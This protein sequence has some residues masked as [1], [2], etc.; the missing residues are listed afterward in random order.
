MT[1]QHL[2]GAQ[3]LNSKT[4]ST[5]CLG[6]LPSP[7]ASWA[8]HEY[9]YAGLSQSWRRR[10]PLLKVKH[11]G[12]PAGPQM[13]VAFGVVSSGALLE[14]ENHSG[15]GGDFFTSTDITLEFQWFFLN[16]IKVTVQ[17]REELT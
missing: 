4:S 14:A 12:N 15:G 5:A 8:H 2:Q 13:Y 6:L 10:L 17:R 3:T 7:S 16:N 1:A 11:H 9:A